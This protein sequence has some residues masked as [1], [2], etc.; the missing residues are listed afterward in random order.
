LGIAGVGGGLGTCGDDEFSRA[1]A[2]ETPGVFGCGLGYARFDESDGGEGFAEC[3]AV[4]L[5]G[6]WVF[7]SGGVGLAAKTM[8]T[9]FWLER[10]LPASVVEPVERSE[11]ARFA[12][13]CGAVIVT[14]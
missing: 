2:L 14:S 12:V 3:V 9:E 7:E 1:R 5:E 10:S 11:F 8:F 13:S 6:G 4:E